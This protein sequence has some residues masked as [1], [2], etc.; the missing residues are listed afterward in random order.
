MKTPMKEF[1]MLNAWHALAF[2]FF[3]LIIQPS[4]IR[5]Q[6][7]TVEDPDSFEFQGDW[8]VKKTMLGDYEAKLLFYPNASGEGTFTID[9]PLKIYTKAKLEGKEGCNSGYNVAN[10][11]GCYKCPPGFTWNILPD[12]NA[13][14]KCSKGGFLGIGVTNAKAVQD[15]NQPKALVPGDQKFAD[16]G[17]IYSCPGGYDMQVLEAHDNYNK[18]LK[19]FKKVTDYDDYYTSTTLEKIFTKSQIACLTSGVECYVAPMAFGLNFRYGW[20]CGIRYGARLNSDDDGKRENL[21][22]SSGPVDIA[23]CACK[24][25]DDDNWANYYVQPT[26]DDSADTNNLK[27]CANNANFYLATL[28]LIQDNENYQLSPMEQFALL[29]LRSEFNIVV[30]L[31]IGNSGDL[32]FSLD[33]TPDHYRLES[34]KSL[35]SE[36][37]EKWQELAQH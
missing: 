13:A 37:L 25:H 15:P 23:D 10:N 4:T 30:G 2:A 3:A 11:G 1:S 17:K 26:G 27:F 9:I 31:N 12:I 28:A 21:V 20:Y 24:M 29:K 22:K 8:L 16:L 32:P 35:A 5:A 14:N 34:S 6:T 19:E 7:S 33:C 18:C 36:I